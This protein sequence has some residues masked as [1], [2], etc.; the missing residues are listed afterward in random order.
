[1]THWFVDFIA[2]QTRLTYPTDSCGENENGYMYK[3]DGIISTGRSEYTQE[4]RRTAGPI[5]L[6]YTLQRPLCNARRGWGIVL[7]FI[8]VSVVNTR[9]NIYNT[10][11]IHNQWYPVNINM[12][13]ARATVLLWKSQGT[14]LRKCVYVRYYY[15]CNNPL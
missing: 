12:D 13:K 7:F 8:F 14:E 9:K 4:R 5:I 11:P 15:V 6:T 1:M 10:K 2:M 3:Y